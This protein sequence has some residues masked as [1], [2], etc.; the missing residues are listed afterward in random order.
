MV[1]QYRQYA[2]WAVTA[3]AEYK[4]LIRASFPHEKRTQSCRKPEVVVIMQSSIILYKIIPSY[5]IDIIIYLYYIRDR[6]YLPTLYNNTRRYIRVQTGGHAKCKPYN[7][8]DWHNIIY[9][10]SNMVRVKIRDG[11]RRINDF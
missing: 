6:L 4:Q 3:A 10:K 9:I 5:H 2:V 11:I 7:I 8:R 1:C